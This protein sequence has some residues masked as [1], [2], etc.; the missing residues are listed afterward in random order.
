MD[1]IDSFPKDMGVE[2]LS[3][4]LTGRMVCYPVWVTSSSVVEDLQIVD[5]YPSC[6]S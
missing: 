2:V 1:E 6:L 3:M 5:T 4:H